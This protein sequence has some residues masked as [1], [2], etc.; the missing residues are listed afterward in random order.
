DVANHRLLRFA[1]AVGGST[2]AA[3]VLGHGS[4]T[5][6]MANRLDAKSAQAITDVAIRSDGRFFATD[7]LSHRVLSF[8]SVLSLAPNPSAD[9]VY[10]QVFFDT[11]R[12]N[13]QSGGGAL[14]ANDLQA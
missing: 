3:A 8:A 5:V 14:Q 6:R 11:S 9:R 13:N 10:G 4:P 1:N 2:S 7:A 12:A